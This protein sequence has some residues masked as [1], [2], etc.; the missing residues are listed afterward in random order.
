[1]GGEAVHDGRKMQ[2]YG[3]GENISSTTGL[4]T[5]VSVYSCECSLHYSMITEIELKHHSRKL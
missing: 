3:M 2:I 1:M 5:A 4:P